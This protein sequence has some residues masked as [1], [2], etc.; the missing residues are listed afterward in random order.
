MKK[1]IVL[2][3]SLFPIISLGDVVTCKNV[4]VSQVTVEGDRDDGFYFSNNMVLMLKDQSG[5]VV[6]CG[7]KQYVSLG[8]NHPA[9]SAL[10]SVAL[11]AQT[12][13]QSVTVLV[14]TNSN[15]TTMLSNQLGAIVINP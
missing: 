15:V 10:L 8:L 12:T 5:N 2:I 13:K 9:F 11:T 3:I 1:L 14:N 4:I 7:D 6:S